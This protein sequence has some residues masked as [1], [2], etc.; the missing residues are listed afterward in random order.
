MSV[1]RIEVG[2]LPAL[3]ADTFV[4]TGKKE[5]GL[6]SLAR[7]TEGL[8]GGQKGSRQLHRRRPRRH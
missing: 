3:A 5:K 4:V 7:L 1:T 8:T 2:P 6:A